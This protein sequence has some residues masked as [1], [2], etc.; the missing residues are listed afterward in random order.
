MGGVFNLFENLV[1]YSNED[2]FNIKLILLNELDQ[3]HPKP[4]ISLDNSRYELFNLSYEEHPANYAK[5]LDKIISNLPGVVVASFLPELASLHLFRKKNKKIV[6]CI[7]DDSYLENAIKYEFLIDKYIIHNPGIFNTFRNSNNKFKRKSN[8]LPYGIE[9]SNIS[10]KDRQ[11]TLTCVFIGRHVLNKGIL[12]IEKINQ[13]LLRLNIPVEWKIFGDGKDTLKFRNSLERFTNISFIR[14]EQ[15]NELYENLSESD[16]L[17]HPSILDG[18]PVAI[19]EAM[20]IG[21]VPIVYRFNSGIDE[22]LSNKCGIV[23]NVGDSEAIVHKIIEF[24]KKRDELSE[25]SKNAV[26]KVKRQ[27]DI[28][29]Q[30]SEYFHFF[31]KTNNSKKQ[32]RKI[33]FI[34]YY[35]GYLNHPLVPSI[36]RRMINKIRKISR[37]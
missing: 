35:K 26:E 34:F 2:Q 11:N 4:T 33:K 30:A 10:K 36:I 16:L 13:E 19:I 29:K 22:V 5:R 18:L 15:K 14:Y 21:V 37:K 28:R 1:T 6:Y 12:E 3:N 23:V 31:L 17:I 25:Y 9:I 24:H 8:Y 20:S 32:R 27:Y 7:H